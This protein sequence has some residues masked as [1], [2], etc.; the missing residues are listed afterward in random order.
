MNS[1][2]KEKIAPLKVCVSYFESISGVLR[3]INQTVHGCQHTFAL[4]LQLFGGQTEGELPL[5]PSCAV[6]WTGCMTALLVLR[7]YQTS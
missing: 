6:L 2:V 1:S 7:V 4:L 5:L 3:F